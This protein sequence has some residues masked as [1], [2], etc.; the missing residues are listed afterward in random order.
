MNRYF[1][2][3]IIFSTISLSAQKL[4]SEA[5]LSV[6][7]CAPYDE[8]YAAF[9]HSALR[10]TDPKNHIDQVYNWGTFDYRTPYFYVKFSRGKLDYMLS[11][12]P[13]KGFLRSYIEEKRWVKEQILNLDSAE[14]QTIYEFAQNNALE[15]NRYYRYDFFYDNCT[16]RIKDVLKMTLGD[17]LKLGK[18]GL[19]EGTTY[20]DM[21][22]LYLTEKQ[23]VE[24]GIDAVLGLPADKTV[25][26]EEATFL[27]DYLE[28]VL[29]NSAV[30]TSTGTKPLVSETHYLYQPE[31]METTENKGI[32][33]VVLL[34]ILLGIITGISV[35][36]LKKKL[37]FRHLD[38]AFFFIIGLIGLLITF[39]WFATDH[40]ATVN[41]LNIAW[42]MPLH[43]IAIFI[44]V[45]E[46]RRKFM[47]MYFLGFGIFML[48][49]GILTFILPQDIHNAA[50]PLIFSS[51]IRSFVIW[52][53]ER[54]FA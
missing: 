27:P 49:F 11:V 12:Y 31:K 23:A 24:F 7:T 34:W 4:S 5:K 48:I 29:E 22:H 50:I 39:L 8:L 44:L 14:K 9:G 35:L 1:L 10:V 17:K 6:I 16:T 47:S 33:L 32:T 51:S 38:Y 3:L 53:R 20:R 52:Q 42:A 2:L 13:Y 30:T 54:K 43:L 15:E 25:T 28:S 19:P 41:N 45:R 21:L 40:T 18:S 37:N 46:R 36:E 26:D